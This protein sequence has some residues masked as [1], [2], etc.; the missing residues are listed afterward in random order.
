MEGML[1]RLLMVTALAVGC[2][3]M[4]RGQV[5]QFESGGL[6]FQTLS[7]KGLTVMFAQLPGHLR[8]YQILQ[9]GIA[10]GSESSCV[11]RPEDYVYE[12]TD[13]TRLYATPAK[14]VV[15]EVLERATR[16]DIIK[17]ISTYENSLNGVSRF[18]STN[19]YEARRQNFLAESG[20]AR[21]RAAAA[22][23][24]I[25]LV[26][27]RL[28]PGEST[29]GAVFFFAGGKGAVLGPGR[30]VVRAA[31]QVFEFDTETAATGRTLQQRGPENESQ[32]T[33]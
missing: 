33:P 32:P 25:A 10:N 31:G 29:D 13:G 3:W 12:R 7:K 14:T 16:G 9:T 4:V 20:S 24:A 18:R 30:L 15:D 23:S 5:I 6:H 28:K 8:D 27:T 22:A 1:A 2:P 11:I 19:G 17:L 21:L 26:N